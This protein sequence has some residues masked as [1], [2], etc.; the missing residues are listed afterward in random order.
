VGVVVSGHAGAAAC[1]HVIGRCRAPL[2]RGAIAP[3]LGAIPK[4]SRCLPL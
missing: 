1:V 3:K 4:G 2:R